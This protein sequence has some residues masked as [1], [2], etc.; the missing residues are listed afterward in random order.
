MKKFTILLCSLTLV[1]GVVGTVSAIP[2][3]DVI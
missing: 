3:T 1:F 2:Y